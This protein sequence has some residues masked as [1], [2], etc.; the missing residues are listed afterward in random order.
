MNR[1]LLLGILS[2]FCIQSNAQKPVENSLL[3]EIK[4]PGQAQPSYLFGTI[5]LI[6]AKD[7]SI[8]DS[9]KNVFSKTQQLALE[10]DMDDPGM[11]AKMMKTMMMSGDTQLKTLLTDNEYARLN[12]FYKDSI[13]MSIDM[14]NKMKPF[15][16]MAPLYNKVMN[17][18]PQ[19]YEMKLVAMAT[20]Q[21]SEVI[22]IETIEEQMAVFD[23]ISYKDQI[24][25]VLNM[26]DSL[27]KARK[28][29]SEM[30]EL[31]K[32]GQMNS[33]YQVS[34]QSDYGMEG[35]EKVLLTDRNHRW[36]SRISKMIKNKPT[37]F[38]VGAAHLGGPDGVVELLRKNGYGLRPIYNQ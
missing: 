15:I 34:I 7:F 22:G 4:S 19:S 32:T 13:G 35:D 25:M 33:L 3:W 37:F 30:I 17:C 2:F 20:Q 21:K 11:T 23:T 8:S 24:K 38:A 5:H 12:T 14:F 6:C 1:L 18:E 10:I 36:I 28:E 29:L 16:L 26:V 31:Y 9:L 27:P